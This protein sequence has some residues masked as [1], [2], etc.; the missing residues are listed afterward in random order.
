VFP[1]GG[2]LDRYLPTSETMSIEQL[3]TV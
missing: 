3:S 1:S 2:D